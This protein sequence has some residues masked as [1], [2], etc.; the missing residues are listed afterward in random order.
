MGKS[1]EVDATPRS[2]DGQL[3]FLMEMV[4][5]MKPITQS[6]LGSRIATVHNGSKPLQ[7]MQ[8]VEKAIL[9]DILLKMTGSIVLCNF[10]TICFTTLELQRISGF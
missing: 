7:A 4:D 9:E 1:E 8:V 5:K 6:P 10:Q 3:L 2:S